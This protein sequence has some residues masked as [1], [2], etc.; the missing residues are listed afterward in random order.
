MATTAKCAL[1]GLTVLSVGVGAMVVSSVSTG[2]WKEGEFIRM[3]GPTHTRRFLGLP[4]HVGTWAS[5]LGPSWA[6]GSGVQRGWDRAM[7][8]FWSIVVFFRNMLRTP[9]CR[10]EMLSV[11]LSAAPVVTGMLV[12]ALRDA[13][14]TAAQVV[15]V[16]LVL[17]AGQVMTAGAALT[18]FYVPFYAWMR[19]R[20]VRSHPDRVYPG[21]PPAP[22]ALSLMRLSM[23]VITTATFATTFLNVTRDEWVWANIAFQLYPLAIL[24]LALWP[25]LRQRLGP[26]GAHVTNTL[27]AEDGAVI[28]HA[29]RQAAAVYQSLSLLLFAGHWFSISLLWAPSKLLLSSLWT[30]RSALL[31][32]PQLLSQPGAYLDQVHH[33]VK[34]GGVVSDGEW[35][36]AF[37]LLGVLAT[38]YLLVLIDAW[39]D[40][41]QVAIQRKTKATKKRVHAAR[42]VLEDVRSCR[43]TLC[44]PPTPPLLPAPSAS[45]SL[46]S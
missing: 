32:V 21:P 2:P 20:Q 14:P 28:V 43:C 26:A 22:Y 9:L 40:E 34:E 11:S 25:W 27:P 10:G 17:S 23:L 18:L 45:L 41:W 33:V 19:V 5:L 7:D 36:L 31:N 39:A 4:P 6:R 15:Y 16:A 8:L 13:S 12:D 30:H 38:Q 3:M 44:S 37:D 1:L 29:N 35:V 24:P 46:P 42:F